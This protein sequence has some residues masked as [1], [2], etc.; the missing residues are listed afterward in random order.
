MNSFENLDHKYIGK[1]LGYYFTD[2][3]VG[4]N[5]PIIGEKGAIVIK[6][7]QRYIE[8]EEQKRGLALVQSPIFSRA[9]IFKKSGHLLH[10]NDIIFKTDNFNDSEFILKPVTC[11]FH[12]IYFKHSVQSYDDLPIGYF[13]TTT[14]FRKIKKGE[15]NG[16]FRTQS[17]TIGDSHVFCRKDQIQNELIKSLDFIIDISKKLE[18]SKDI[19]FVLSSGSSKTDLLGT[20]AE[21]IEARKYL[22]NSLLKKELSYE[23]DEKVAAFYGPKIDVFYT[24]RYSRKTA[25]FTIQLDFQL[26]KQF[27]LTYQ[28]QLGQKEYTIIIHRSSMSCYERMLGILLEK[29]IGNMPFWLAPLQIKIFVI[30]ENAI[31][32]SSTIRNKLISNGFR[33]KS[34]KVTCNKLSSKIHNEITEKTPCIVVIGEKEMR[35]NKLAVRFYKENK[36]E[37]IDFSSFLNK[38]EHLLE[39]IHPMTT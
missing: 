33:V 36:I 12:F 3:L 10:Y 15:Q 30:E 39:S 28:N 2:S 16:L 26:S 8:N 37:T 7:L 23:E 35:E 9:E 13:E 19:S 34:E 22:L 20:E 27:D 4:G 32:Y 5:I 21:W 29:N 25:I 17:F 18:L 24:N 31:E 38:L 11:P 6:V 14:L 1:K